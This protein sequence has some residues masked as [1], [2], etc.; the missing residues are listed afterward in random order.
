MDKIWHMLQSN[1]TVIERIKKLEEQSK[2]M[3]QRMQ[4]MEYNDSTADSAGYGASSKGEHDDGGSFEWCRWR[5]SWWVR[6]D[7]GLNSRQRRK[8]SRSFQRL[9]AR[10]KEGISTSNMMSHVRRAVKAEIMM[11]NASNAHAQQYELTTD[12]ENQE[13]KETRDSDE[14]DWNWCDMN[15]HNSVTR[16]N[17]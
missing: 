7:K 9:V 17:I 15:E 11:R 5:G 4:R 13:D 6:I 10:E 3:Q 12:E 14:T 2:E 8:V 16:P 1:D